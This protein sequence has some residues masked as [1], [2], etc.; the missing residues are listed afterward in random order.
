M[1]KANISI[2]PLMK[3]IAKGLIIHDLFDQGNMGL[4]KYDKE[5]RT[6][7]INENVLMQII[8]LVN[9]LQEARE[10][11]LLKQEEWIKG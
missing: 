5:T 9:P 10:L 8:Q 1:A 6:F 7:L 3:N 11:K 4:L 2:E